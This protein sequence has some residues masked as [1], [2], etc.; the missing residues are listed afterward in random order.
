[1]LTPEQVS[2]VGDAA[3]SGAVGAADVATALMA[4]EVAK[5]IRDGDVLGALARSGQL[6]RVVLTALGA[7]P[8]VPTRAERAARDALRASLAADARAI[9]V[10]VPDAGLNG[11]QAALVSELRALRTRCNL[12]MAKDAADGYRQ[13]V[14]DL[15]PRVQRGELHMERA[16][17]EGVRRMAERGVGVVSY[18]SGRRDQPDVAIRR[19]IQTLTKRA[20]TEGTAEICRRNGVR[21][22]E[23]D[24]H[25]G[26]RDTHRAW[27]GRVY[28][29]DGP[30]TTGDGTRYPGLAESGAE[31]GMRE[32]NCLHSMAPYVHGRARRWSATPDEDAGEDGAEAYRL[33]Q[34]QRAG[35]RRI[36]A[37]KREVAALE[38][39][40]LD[41]T[42]ARLRLG[43][44]EAAQKR[45]LARKGAPR[46]RSG[47]EEAYD[48]RGRR[49][50]VGGAQ[51]AA[52]GRRP[53]GARGGLSGA[54]NKKNDPDGS[55][56]EAHA[57][58]YYRQIR[59]RDKGGTIKKVATS[60]GVSEEEA[61]TAI[62][63]V[64][65]A[66]HDLSE[67]RKRFDADYDMSQSWQRLIEGRPERHDLV[68]L[69][70]EAHEA[71]LMKKGISYE[72]AHKMTV[73]AGYN[74]DKALDDFLGEGGSSA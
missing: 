2:A 42:S 63:H 32:P 70:H 21:L 55:R 29:L 71:E 22:V 15:I 65:F 9:G 16:V 74:Y 30:V 49:I 28:G 36:R 23:V 14:T 52:N 72:E 57:E 3:A 39:E 13:I 56:R 17:E 58:D 26:A 18:T 54:L 37:A 20:A 5:A 19:H 38:A 24:S 50:S 1:M 47:R 48:A 59:H 60:A 62:E 51:S 12:A 35:E 33:R 31:D 68:L 4:A 10:P 73:Q 64:F 67:G 61:A 66:T 25:R 46:R 44:A 41:S 27:Q 7:N 6:P 43:R 40:G 53:T 69:K 8:V 34:R 11:A 45:L